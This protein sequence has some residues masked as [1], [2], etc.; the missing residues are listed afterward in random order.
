MEKTL[1]GGWDERLVFK[2]TRLEPHDGQRRGADDSPG[3]APISGLKPLLPQVQLGASLPR[4]PL[5]V[6][7]QGHHLPCPPWDFQEDPV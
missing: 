2:S 7:I 4:P 1:K 5:L 3:Q 6:V